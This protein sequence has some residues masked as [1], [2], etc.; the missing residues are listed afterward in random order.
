MI[1][2]GINAYHA[3]SSA[4]IFVNGKLIAVIEEER[5]TR[6]KHWAGFPVLAIEF[7]LQQA[8]I[9]LDKVDYF[10][11][12][13]DSK[14]KLINKLWY[15]VK[16]L[17]SRVGFITNRFQNDRKG[18]SIEKELSDMSSFN[19]SFFQGKVIQ[20]DHPRSHIASAFFFIYI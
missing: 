7:C 9:G 20:V 19:E 4:S 1:I 17:F 3:D 8:G 12:G 6:I 10:V 14:D 13:R 11:I 5:L 16:N 15:L 2:I 18:S